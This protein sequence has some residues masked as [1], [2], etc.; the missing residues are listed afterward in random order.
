MKKILGICAAIALTSLAIG[1]G[2]A[3]SEDAKPAATLKVEMTQQVIDRLY[4]LVDRA[5][6]QCGVQCA[7]DAIIVIGAIQKA[8]DSAKT[9]DTPPAE[10]P[11][12]P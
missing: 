6:K 4:G 11:Q 5:V 1:V 7:G 3:R 12:K 10:A 9:G 2:I 8:K